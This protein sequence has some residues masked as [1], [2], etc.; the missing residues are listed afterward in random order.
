[1]IGVQNPVNMILGLGLISLIPLIISVATAFLKMSIVLSLVRNA[2]GVQQVP[3]NMA[4]YGLAL[5]LTVYVM[6]PVLGDIYKIMDANDI[7]IN[8]MEQ[9]I[10][11]KDQLFAPYV[12]FLKRNTNVELSTVFFETA[13]TLWP[14][15][16]ANG[17]K[18]DDFIILLPSFITSELN[19]AFQI[20]FLIFIP[21][22]VIDIFVS[23]ILLSLGMMMVAPMTISLP[24]KLLLFV[25][26]DGWTKLIDSLILTYA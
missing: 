6:Y 16:Y 26:A 21:F 20:A 15:E 19:S 11:F 7:S 23:N 1:M 2:L 8:D 18:I 25:V 24:F 17:V 10:L 5:I 22:L 4:L 3:P 12:D 14:P 9:V 13:K